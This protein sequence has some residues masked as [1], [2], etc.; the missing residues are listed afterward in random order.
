MDAFFNFAIVDGSP[1]DYLGSGQ[2]DG[3]GISANFFSD[4]HVRKGFSY[5]FDLDKYI[6]T[7]FHGQAIQHRGPIIAGLLGYNENS[8]VYSHDAGL[9]MQELGQAWGG[10]VASKGFTLTIA[11]NEGNTT[12]Q[13]F[14]EVLK[15]S[16]EALDPKFHVNVI[17]LP[18]SDYL[19]DQRMEALPLFVN[20]WMAGHPSPI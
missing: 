12:R 7:V 1:R 18:W 19:S 3:N 15:T 4:I 13:T 11:Y 5:A 16:L 9:A 8:T 10:Q 20:G 17:S 6:D 14:A 2:L